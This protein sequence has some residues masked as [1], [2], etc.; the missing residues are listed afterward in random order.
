MGKVWVLDTST[1]GT[2]ATMVPLE[3]V[4][5]EPTPPAKPLVV[6]RAGRQ[7]PAPVPEPRAPRSFKVVD[8]M[9]RQV[10]TE[11]VDARAAIEVLKD[12]HS[13][14][15]VNVYVWQPTRETW[16]LLSLDEK[17]LIWDRRVTA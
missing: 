13:I 11:G 14:V 10:L 17:R 3:K 9:T 4:E 2:G 1:K 8:I 15:D 6:R 7:K 16:R 12:V 5:R